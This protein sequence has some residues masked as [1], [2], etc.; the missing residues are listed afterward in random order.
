M[1]HYTTL[2]VALIIA[3]IAAYFSTIGIALIFSGSYWA[4]I[5]MGC[6]LEA[7][8]IMSVS[9]LYRHWNIAHFMLKTYLLIAIVVLSLITSLG[10]FGF[11]SRAHIAQE[12]TLETGAASQIEL[13]DDQ[14][15]QK[16]NSIADIDKR[17]ALIDDAL[18]Q[19]IVTNKAQTSIKIADQQKKNREALNAERSR[20]VA[21]LNTLNTSRINL[22]NDV[23]TAAV[24][25]GPIRYFADFFF[26]KSDRNTLERAVRWFIITIIF[27]FDPT[28]IALLIAFQTGIVHKNRLKKDDPN[29][30]IIDKND[31]G[32]IS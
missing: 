29:T 21:D 12:A 6:T 13:I 2:L 1:V 18:R 10:I 25:V 4:A 30:I 3:S 31:L 26:D 7:G 20:I 16:K 15:T 9:W 24:E 28:S 19:M 14:I 27:V 17:V 8:K 5:I 32:N 11:L 22:N 23:K